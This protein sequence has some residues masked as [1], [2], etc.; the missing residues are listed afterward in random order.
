MPMYNDNCTVVQ[1]CSL[2]GCSGSSCLIRDA[3]Q[4][5]RAVLH[6]HK[7]D[8]YIGA[9]LLCADALCF[10]SCVWQ[11]LQGELPG[12]IVLADAPTHGG[13]SS[14]SSTKPLLARL[15]AIW[16]GWRGCNKSLQV[17][18]AARWVC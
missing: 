13:C 11:V 17:V 8:S 16:K 18:A 4:L 9:G 3:R 12:N 15:Q 6:P 10:S 2:K 14:S 1:L 7:V 5:A